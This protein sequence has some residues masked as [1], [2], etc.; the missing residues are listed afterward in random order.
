MR[1]F[2]LLSVGHGLLLLFFTSMF[3]LSPTCPVGAQVRWPGC[4]MVWPAPLRVLPSVRRT[5]SASLALL[6]LTTWGRP[7]LPGLPLSLAMGRE[8][9]AKVCCGVCGVR[10]LLTL[11]DRARWPVCT[12]DIC[13]QVCMRACRHTFIYMYIHFNPC[14]YHLC[15]YMST[16]HSSVI[17]LLPS[18]Y[19]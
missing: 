6:L 16:H 11:S 8:L 10:V 19:L 12:E 2:S 9:G 3:R 5:L 4:L 1:G 13:V 18:I 17:Y 7:L 15:V 14:V